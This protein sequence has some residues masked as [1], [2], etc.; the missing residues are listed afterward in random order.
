MKP[1][2]AAIYHYGW[3][4]P[5]Q[6]Q[7]AKQQAFHR[8]WHDE[9]WMKENIPQVNEFDYSQIDS[10]VK[11]TGMHPKV[12]QQRIQNKNWTFSF[13]PTKKKLSVKMKLLNFIEKTTG[14]KVGEYRN[15]KII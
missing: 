5:P 8:L 2:N 1:I 12:M 11:F 10:L 4:K 13:D 15:Y 14:W 9:K 7:Q 3:V 6:A